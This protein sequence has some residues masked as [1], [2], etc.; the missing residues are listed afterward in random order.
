MRPTRDL[1]RLQGAGLKRLDRLRGIAMSCTSPTAS[2]VELETG[3]AYCVVE[4][5]N[6]WY[7][8]SRSLYLSSAFGARDGGGTRITLANVPRAVSVDDALT[9][10]IRR[11][12]PWLM[13]RRQPPWTW[14]DEPSW[15]NAAVLL[16]ALDEIGASNRATVAAAL[17]LPGATVANLVPFR[18]FM[19]HRGED[20]ARRLRPL[21]ARYAISPSLRATKALATR[22]S[23]TQGLRPFPL[24]VDWVDDVQNIITL[25]V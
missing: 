8:I 16:D 13:N 4:L 15:A 5:Y 6:C 24:L 22:A 19:S 2:V 21:L 14:I 10:A 17:S 9:H 20:T 12:K 25:I 7:S 23:G 11:S 18:H 1:R 3:V